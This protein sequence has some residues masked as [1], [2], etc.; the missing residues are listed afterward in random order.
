MLRRAWQLGTRDT[1]ITTKHLPIGDFEAPE[2]FRIRIG[3][4]HAT[5]EILRKRRVEFELR[6]ARACFADVI[7]HR[8]G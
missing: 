5:T 2:R 6:A 3:V 7:D 8:A 4:D 1:L